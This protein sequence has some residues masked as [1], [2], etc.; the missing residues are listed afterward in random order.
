MLQYDHFCHKQRPT[1]YIIY[2]LKSEL[3]TFRERVRCLFAI[4]HFIYST[5]KLFIYCFIKLFALNITIYLYISVLS[6]TQNTMSQ[7]LARRQV[8]KTKRFIGMKVIVSQLSMYFYSHNKHIP[9]ET[10][11]SRFYCEKQPRS[12]SL[13]HSHFETPFSPSPASC[14]CMQPPGGWW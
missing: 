10:C 6:S 4:E 14:G 5:V 8:W 12:V 3:S 2:G 9:V 11:F 13:T 1:R 7:K